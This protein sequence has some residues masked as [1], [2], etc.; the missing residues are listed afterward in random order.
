MGFSFISRA[1]RTSA[2]LLQLTLLLTLDHAVAAPKAQPV[3]ERA[4]EG[5]VPEGFAM[6]MIGVR[7]GP[8]RTEEPNSATAFIAAYEY[9]D[10]LFRAGL[11]SA[12][13]ADRLWL[14][15]DGRDFTYEF[16]LNGSLGVFLPV[17]S[18]HGPVFRG[19]LRSEALQLTGLNLTQVAVP[20]GE[21]GYSYLN[22]PNQLEFVG[23]MGP[24]LAGE[25]RRGDQGVSLSGLLW[26][27]GVTARWQALSVAV[28]AA[29]TELPNSQRTMR[30]VAHVCGILGALRGAPRSKSPMDE[31]FLAR[32]AE[33]S[34]KIRVSLCADL[35][36]IQYWPGQSERDTMSVTSVG[37]SLLLGNISRLYTPDADRL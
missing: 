8:L 19:A 23:L 18:H 29:F 32:A 25:L 1:R 28:D 24:S 17:G 11:W 7:T 37:L 12:R 5:L 21:I 31:S 15:Y 36:S 13:Y 35:S 14:G 30:G 16:A 27:A 33:D 20:A 34:R 26:G 22:G 3:E 2:A 6:R 4:P 9:A 10:A